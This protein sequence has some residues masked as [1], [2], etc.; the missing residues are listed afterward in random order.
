MGN[1]LGWLKGLN[2]VCEGL[3][4]TSVLPEIRKICKDYSKTRQRPI[5]ELVRERQLKFIG[6]C[7][8]MDK[9]EPANTYTLYKPE[10]GQNQVEN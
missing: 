7:L 6:H 4:L 8:R 5:R 10:V 9:E 3:H 2:S 1:I